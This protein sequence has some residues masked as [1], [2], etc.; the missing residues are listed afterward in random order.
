M[1]TALILFSAISFFV[2]GSA[3]FFS[4]YMKGE[5]TRWGFGAQRALV[6]GLQ[7]CAVVGLLAG[8]EQPLL[9]RAASVG[10]ALMMLVAVGV[11]IRIKDSIMQTI[12][13]LLYLVLQ[14]YL[15]LAAF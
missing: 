13:A 6:G 4:P 7:L 10:L 5:F 2:Y 1:N 11:R 14:V 3:C 9:G 15:S 8:F 12:P